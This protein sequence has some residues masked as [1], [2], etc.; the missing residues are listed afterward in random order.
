MPQHDARRNPL[1]TL[2][3]EFAGPTGPL[4]KRAQGQTLSAQRWSWLVV[5]PKTNDLAM[6]D[7]S[8]SCFDALNAGFRQWWSDTIGK[9]KVAKWKSRG[10]LGRIP[11]KIGPE[12]VPGHAKPGDKANAKAAALRPG[13][14]TWLL[15][16]PGK[17]QAGA[18]N[19][20]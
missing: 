18:L 11:Q 14:S 17:Q 8:V 1:T 9:A 4:A 5:N 19:R 7:G 15:S 16:E 12:K 3:R 6:R 2:T 13:R 10:L 20:R